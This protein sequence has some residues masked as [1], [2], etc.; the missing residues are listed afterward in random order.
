MSLDEAAVTLISLAVATVILVSRAIH[1]SALRAAGGPKFVVSAA[2]FGVGM[3]IFALLQE[4]AASDVRTDIRY[5]LMYTVMGLAWI[6]VCGGVYRFY[7][8]DV[9]RD[10]LERRNAA[11]GVLWFGGLLAAGLA[12]AG[13][14]FGDG[15]GWW[16][17]VYSSGLAT[18]TLLALWFTLDRIADVTAQVTIDRSPAV[19]FRF[20][21]FLVVAGAILG[22][23]AAG[24]WMGIGAA[25]SDFVRIGSAVILLA[26]LEALL[27]RQTRPTADTPRPSLVVAGLLPAAFYAFAGTFYLALVGRWS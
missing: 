27:G 15:P 3:V 20:A 26:V 11:A 9:T 23:A 2:P 7:G 24:T 16:V 1:A 12:Y 8:L 4:F 22:R 14:N 5:L 6:S 17:V 19:A 13:G 10:W 21:T 25:T 18:L